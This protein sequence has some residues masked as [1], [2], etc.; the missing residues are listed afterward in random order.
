MNH[1]SHP[2][3]DPFSRGTELNWTCKINVNKKWTVLLPTETNIERAWMRRSVRNEAAYI[4]TPKC[5]KEAWLMFRWRP[6]QYQGVRKR[7]RSRTTFSNTNDQRQVGYPPMTGSLAYTILRGACPCR[8]NTATPSHTTYSQ[9]WHRDGKRMR[10]TLRWCCRLLKQTKYSMSVS[11]SV[12]Q[13][14]KQTK[15]C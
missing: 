2:Q 9:S 6:W 14:N 12:K 4:S 15:T 3:N 1:P 11:Q 5:Y 13:T 10:S 8:Q 7:S